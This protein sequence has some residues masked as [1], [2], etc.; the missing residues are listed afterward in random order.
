MKVLVRGSGDVASAVAHRLFSL[1]HAVLIHE[2]EHPHYTRRGMA[3]TDAVFEGKVD[4]QG[5]W[6]KRPQTRRDLRC[7]LE[8]GRAIPVF[9]GPLP[10]ALHVLQPDVLVDARMYKRKLPEVQKGLS[11]LTIGLGPNFVAGEH[12]DL[13]IETAWGVQLG[14]VLHA[15]PSLPLEGE[16]RAIAG[17]SRERFV[18][19]PLAGLFTHAVAIGTWVNAGDPVA[20]LDGLP[21]TAPING[22]VRGI[23]HSGIHVDAGMRLLEIDPRS[24]DASV[25]GLGE[26]PLRIAEAVAQVLAAA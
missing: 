9:V 24:Q 23:C 1:G 7:M 14:T 20:L 11:P 25:Y 2:I 13:V 26:R 19:A 10:E 15:G 12:T 17:L 8:C 18:H 4:L 6:A 16:P 22:H 21:I 3:F 5:V